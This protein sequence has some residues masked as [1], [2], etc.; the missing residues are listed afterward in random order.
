MMVQP[1]GIR[2]LTGWIKRKKKDAFRMSKKG[3]SIQD[4]AD[5]S[6][7]GIGTVPLWIQDMPLGTE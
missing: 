5:I 3:L 7:Q 2:L 1:A 6:G 4:I